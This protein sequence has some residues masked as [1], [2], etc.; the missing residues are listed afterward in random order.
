[1]KGKIE[2][3]LKAAKKA[4]DWLVSNQR[5]DPVCVIEFSAKSESDTG[6]KHHDIQPQDGFHMGSVGHLA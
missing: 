4:S 3:Y 1:M 2:S 5:E 6:G